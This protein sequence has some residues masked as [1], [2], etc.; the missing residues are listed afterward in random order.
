MT[1]H[2]CLVDA[3]GFVFR[4]YY[5]LPA[6]SR[7]D[8]L[9]TG[10]VYGF[11]VMLR[12]LLQSTP[13]THLAVVFDAPGKVFRHTL[14]PAYKANRK[15]PPPDL[16]PQFALVREATAAFGLQALEAQGFEA[17]DLIAT[18]TTLATHTHNAQ[19]TI[20][21]SDKDL[22]QLVCEEVRLYDTM[23][24]RTLGI[25]EVQAHFG[26]KPAQVIDIQAL[27]GDASDNVPG[28]PGIGIK[29]AAQLITTYGSLE[30]LLAR[31]D[32]I[33]QAKRR[34]ALKAHKDKALLSRDLVR[35][36]TDAPQP[37]SFDALTRTASNPQILRDFLTKMEFSQLLR[38]LDAPPTQD[39]KQD[40]HS[41][42]SWLQDPEPTIALSLSHKDGHL[43]QIHLASQTRTGTFNKSPEA[44]TALFKDPGVLKICHGAATVL[45][46]FPHLHPFEDTALLSYALDGPLHEQDLTRLAQHYLN[47]PP[48]Q[49]AACVLALWQELSRRLAGRAAAVLYARIDKPLVSVLRRMEEAGIQVDRHTLKTLDEEFTTRLRALGEEIQTLAGIPFNPGSPK[50]L[51]DVLFKH[52]G[53]EG[54]TK[55]RTGAWRTDSETLYRVDHPLPPLILEWRRFS[56]LKSTYTQALQK[57]I[58][59][60]D[61]RVHT[62]FSQTTTTTGRLSSSHP[63]LQNIPVRTKEG[64]RIRTAFV[65]PPGSVLMSADYNQIELRLLAHMAEVPVL[66]EALAQGV[67]L[68]SFTAREVFGDEGRRREA[69]AVNFGIIYGMSAFGLANQLGVSRQEASEKLSTYFERFAGLKDYM[70]QTKQTA[71]AQGFVETLFGRRCPLPEINSPVPARRAFMERAAINAPLQGSAADIM[72]RAM[73]LMDTAL[74]S[75]KTRMLLQIHDEL[76][77]EV[78]EAEVEEV[79]ALAKTLMRR[80]GA[81]HIEVPVVIRYGSCWT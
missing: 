24:E 35:L 77:L 27:A 10:A 19:V 37:L 25:N 21:S 36:R 9:P 68:H 34:E 58:D 48:E 32:E 33:P 26:A 49:E 57:A 51:G 62:T 31:A 74:G 7:R 79:C 78:P 45:K 20:V 55:T 16:V 11:C 14:Y 46:F 47:N 39:Q 38:A 28:V 59:P 42:E 61:K 4:A 1:P 67:D 40:D 66:R 63:N 71:R 65:A 2:L 43:Y 53:L 12:K 76:L 6:L 80:A 29:T 60:E 81:P 30:A 50:Q 15:A 44:L 56:K 75:L 18:Y 41:L 54:G 5:A 69:K 13:A 8:G 17:D 64:Q 73:I 52:L 72:R 22:M 3:Y 70:E 23:K